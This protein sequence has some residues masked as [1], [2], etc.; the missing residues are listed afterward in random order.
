MGKMVSAFDSSASWVDVSRCEMN[1]HIYHDF[2]YIVP[3]VIVSHRTL[4]CQVRHFTPTYVMT[5]ELQRYKQ[6]L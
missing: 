5:K 6:C 1:P 3:Q 2:L 4:Q